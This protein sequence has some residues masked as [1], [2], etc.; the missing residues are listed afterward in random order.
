M[1]FLSFLYPLYE[2]LGDIF[3]YIIYM[4]KGGDYM[5]GFGQFAYS[6]GSM[7]PMQDNR[8]TQQYGRQQIM[9]NTGVMATPLS[10]RVVT[11]IEEARASQISLDGTPS[12]FPSPAEGKIYVKS[13]DMNGL[14]VFL[15]YELNMSNYGNQIPKNEENM[16]ISSLV[17]RIDAIESKLKE[18]EKNGSNAINSNA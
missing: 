14:P 16:Q 11:G 4:C 2:T 6:P 17:C 1:P 10:G 13:L 3:F 12:Y 5:Y 15:T 18:I 9:P 8:M 7:S